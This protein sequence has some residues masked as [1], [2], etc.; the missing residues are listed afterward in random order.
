MRRLRGE[1]VHQAT[2][3]T[4][5]GLFLTALSTLM[6]EILL[7]RIFSVTMW[8][9]FAFVAV[10]LAMFGLTVGAIIV[11]LRPEWFRA[12]VLSRRLALSAVAYPV[13]VVVTFLVQLSVPF[14]VH[15]SVVGIF[16]IGFV[17]AVVSIPF[18]ASG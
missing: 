9:H 18:V 7:T 5:M 16:A 15:P 10:S 14:I 12:E 13:L 4:V 11:F 3:R 8:Y 17:Y 1:S 6:H 2:W